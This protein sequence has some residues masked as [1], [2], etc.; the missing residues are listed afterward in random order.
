MASHSNTGGIYAPLYIQCISILPQWLFYQIE[1]NELA[2][3]EPSTLETVAERLRFYRI[4]KK[5][6]QIDVAK[7]AGLSRCVYADYEKGVEIYPLE[8]ITKIAELFEVSP[9]EFV[10]DYNCFLQKGQGCQ[11]RAIRNTLNMSQRDF[12]EYCGVDKSAVD[13]WELDKVVISKR[14]WK[15]KFNN[16]I[17]MTKG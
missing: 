10:D 3:S 12:A 4:Q 7:Y 15:K 17:E 13:K 1:K 16:L 14:T 8:R 11:I 5:L 6:R 2:D 9:N